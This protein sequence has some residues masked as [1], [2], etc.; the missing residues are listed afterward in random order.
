MIIETE[1]LAAAR[2][3]LNCYGC[4]NLPTHEL[5]DRPCAVLNLLAI[6]TKAEQKGVCNKKP[7][8]PRENKLKTQVIVE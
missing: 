8:T 6:V 1:E 7:K 4:A 2:K 3:I 5:D